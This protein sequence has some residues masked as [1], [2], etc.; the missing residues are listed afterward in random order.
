MTEQRSSSSK[1][2]SPSRQRGGRFQKG[3]SGNPNGRPNGSRNRATLA[4]EAL[5]DGEAERITRKVIEMALAGDIVALRLCLERLVPVRHERPISVPIPELNAAT[6][7]AAKFEVL[8]GAVADGRLL[9][10][11]GEKLA[12]LLA[13]QSKAKELDEL[14]QRV[15]ALEQAKESS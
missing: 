4:L 14:E 13:A 5:L 12:N 2:S 7:A 15:V 9:P 10:S 11:E 3:V 6:G 1:Q 8:I